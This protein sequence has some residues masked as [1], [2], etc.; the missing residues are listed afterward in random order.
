MVDCGGVA[1]VLETTAEHPFWVVGRGW[2]AVA[3]LMPGDRLLDASGAVLAVD[4]L[5][6]TGRTDTVYNIEVEGYHT[7]FVGDLGVWVHNK[8]M[9]NPL[10]VEKGL[11]GS[12][13]HG[14]KWT[15]GPARAKSTGNRRASLAAKPT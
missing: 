11:A 4:G 8:A 6:A 1:E 15:E 5:V 7:Y 13:K 12:K 9:R 2:V 3:D 14:L 10:R